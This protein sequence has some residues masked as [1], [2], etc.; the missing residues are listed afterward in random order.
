MPM[1]PIVTR[2]TWPRFIYDSLGAL[3]SKVGSSFDLIIFDVGPTSQLF[4][5]L[6]SSSL[7]INAG[8][9]VHNG[10]GISNFQK[11]RDL[12]Q[13]FGVSKYLVAQNSVRQPGADVHPNVA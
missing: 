8:L 3:T 1:T 11:T 4:A 10:T 6:S 12:L 2:V 13:E 7:M 5:E 9:I